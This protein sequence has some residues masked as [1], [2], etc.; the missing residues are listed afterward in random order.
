MKDWTLNELFQRLLKAK[1]V[2]KGETSTGSYQ[3]YKPTGGSTSSKQN[4]P[5]MG[6]NQPQRN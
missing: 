5:A 4:G 6:N 2:G 3:Q 1:S